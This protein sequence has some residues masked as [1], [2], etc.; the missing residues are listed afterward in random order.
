MEGLGEN[1]AEI[2]ELVIALMEEGDF[3][4]K[5]IFRLWMVVSEV[6]LGNLR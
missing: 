1:S 4:R 2:N 5:D 6:E 3:K